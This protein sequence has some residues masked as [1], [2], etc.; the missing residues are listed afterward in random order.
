MDI[1]GVVGKDPADFAAVEDARMLASVIYHSSGAMYPHPEALGSPAN[2]HAWFMPEET[3]RIYTI[4]ELFTGMLLATGTIGLL[5]DNGVNLFPQYL[6]KE[7]FSLDSTVEL[8]RLMSEPRARGNGFGKAIIDSALEDFKNKTVIACV[9]TEDLDVS[10]WYQRNRFLLVGYFTGKRGNK[11]SVYRF[12][13][14]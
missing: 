12:D 8:G 4:R 10:N 13:S 3:L 7:G 5:K 2:F 9:N 6:M 11:L 1:T 14:V